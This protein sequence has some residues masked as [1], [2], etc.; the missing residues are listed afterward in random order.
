MLATD[1]PMPM[2]IASPRRP[3]STDD[4]EEVVTIAPAGNVDELST[5]VWLVVVVQLDQE[6]AP[7]FV[8]KRIVTVGTAIVVNIVGASAQLSACLENINSGSFPL[9]P[10]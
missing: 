6:I 3:A 1:I 10:N 2:P 7:K 9:R 4:N 5:A 8:V